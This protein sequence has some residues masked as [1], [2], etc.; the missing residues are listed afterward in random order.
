MLSGSQLPVVQSHPQVAPTAYSHE[1]ACRRTQTSPVAR[2]ADFISSA[3]NTRP[4]S[5]LCFGNVTPRKIVK[6]ERIQ[7]KRTKGWRIPANTVKVDRTTKWGNP[8]IPGKPAPFG[9]TKGQVVADKRHAFLLYQS[10][11]PLNPT[12][13]A[14]ARA[15]LAGKN[16]ACWCSMEDPYQDACHAAVLI[17]LANK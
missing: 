7:L 17:N 3:G 15:E 16:L 5:L 1:T 14:A 9:P 10:L 2:P 12:L 4:A 13:V 8:F 6:P 11:A